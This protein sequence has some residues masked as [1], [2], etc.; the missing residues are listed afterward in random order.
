MPLLLLTLVVMCAPMAV[1]AYSTGATSESCYEMQVFH[2]DSFSGIPASSVDCGASVC[3]Y[4]LSLVSIVAS[5]TNRTRVNGDST[6][7]Q[8]GRVYECKALGRRSRIVGWVYNHLPRIFNIFVIAR[9]KK[10][11]FF[12]P[13]R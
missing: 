5:E 2:S 12:K 4:N 6:T 11:F 13:G 10:R 8:C 7:Y 9:I 3:Q 1:V